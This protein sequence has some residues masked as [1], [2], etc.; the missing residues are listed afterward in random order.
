MLDAFK[1]L[2]GG[3]GKAQKQADDFQALITTAKEERR[4]LNVMIEQITLRGSKLAQVGKTLEQVDQR[5]RRRGKGG[6]GDKRI[7]GLEERIRS[8]GEIDARIQALLAAALQAQQAAEKL[9]APD[10]EL[11]KHRQSVQQLSSQM[12]QTQAS[13]DALKR[14]QSTLEEFRKQLHQTQGEIKSTVDHAAAVRAELDQVRGTAGQLS[15]DYARLR[16]ASKEAREDSV[17]AAETVKELERRLG[18]LVQL[19]ELSKTTEEKLA[20]LNAL[21]EHVS[22]K[23][24]ALEG[25]KHTVERA[26]VEATASTRWSGTWTSRSTAERRA[27]GGEPQRADHQT[28]RNA[29]Q[30]TRHGRGSDQGPRRP[31]ARIGPFEKMGACWWTA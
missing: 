16:D 25:Q 11:Q 31:G 28:H 30:Q 4:A 7:A 26:V 1:G 23:A 6:G 22:Q 10:G 3:G 29:G 12:L 8:F 21:A 5:R 15:Q 9:I 19:Q 27:E 2:T 14:E 18:P 20:G 13:I 24:K 17:A